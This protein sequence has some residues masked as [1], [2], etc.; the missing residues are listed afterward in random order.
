[1]SDM[2]HEQ[3]KKVLEEARNTYGSKNQILVCMEE[4]N[5]LACV[6]AKY[7]R[8]DD[9]KKATE[10]LHDKI[11]DEVADVIVILDHVQNIVGLT[12]IEI[13]QRITAKIERLGRWL[14]HSD[15]MQET[16]EDRKVAVNNPCTTCYRHDIDDD[17]KIWENYCCM[18]YKA[19][20]TEGTAPFYVAMSGLGE[21]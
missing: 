8:Y 13:Q 5:E 15:S 19:Q 2:L 6:L 16:L 14:N 4:L 11:L 10:E 21:Q 18:C 12:D 17:G 20:A 7:P 9:E 1:M 3:E